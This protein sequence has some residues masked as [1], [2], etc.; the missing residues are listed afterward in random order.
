M[1]GSGNKHSAR[2]AETRRR[3][4]E[5][6]RHLFASRSIDSVSLNEITVAAGQ[7][8]RNALQYHFGSK[9]GLLQSIVDLHARR[10]AD[11]RQPYLVVDAAH[12]DNTSQLAARAL[13]CPLIDYVGQNPTAIDYITILSQLAALNSPLFSPDSESNIRFPHDK[14]LETL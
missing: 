9:E 4:I 7:K 13:I 12:E 11:L 3:F 10:V 6:G 8:N 1:A 2:S 14:K 5:A